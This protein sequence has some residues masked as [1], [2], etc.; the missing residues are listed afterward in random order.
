MD[1][2]R[3]KVFV[4]HDNQD[5][6]DNRASCAVLKDT[7]PAF[8]LGLLIQ[9]DFAPYPNYTG[10]LVVSGQVQVWRLGA[11]VGPFNGAVLNYRLTGLDARC[12]ASADVT[13]ANGC[14][15]HIHEGDC[16]DAGGHYFAGDSD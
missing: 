12:T 3:G 1:S 8:G 7:K 14:G 13:A 10:S 6:A 9:A 16:T 5:G 2:I 11:A 4:I 15:I